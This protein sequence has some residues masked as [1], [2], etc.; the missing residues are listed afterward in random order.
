MDLYI[1]IESV[2][3]GPQTPRHPGKFRGRVFG[4]VCISISDVFGPEHVGLS[5]TSW[6]KGSLR[7]F[8][9]KIAERFFTW[10]VDVPV[11]RCT[12]LPTATGTREFRIAKKSKLQNQNILLHSDLD[13]F[14]SWQFETEEKQAVSNCRKKKR[15]DQNAEIF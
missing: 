11:Y 13:G 7:L 12:G 1:G 15:Q 6:L 14:F 9:K 4:E 2:P 8:V 5:L 10:F 3:D